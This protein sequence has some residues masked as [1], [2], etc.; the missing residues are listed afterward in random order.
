MTHASQYAVVI[1]DKSHALPFTDVGAGAWYE[2]AVRYVYTNGLMAGTGAD[3]FSPQ[4]VTTR[5][6]IVTILW[7]LS[8]SPQVNYLLPFDD[9]AE[10]TWYAEAVRWAASEGIVTG[11]SATTFAPGDPITREQLAVMLHRYAQ[12][13]GYDVSQGGMGIWEY[14]DYDEISGWAQAAMD[15]AVSA[16]HHQRAPAKA[17]LAPGGSATRAEAAAMLMR[18]CQQPGA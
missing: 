2:D 3:I 10:G 11:A 13:A 9:V 1:D 6:Q 7:R 16:G 17:T 8:G 15:W 12:H 14:G 5:A 4:G 18:F